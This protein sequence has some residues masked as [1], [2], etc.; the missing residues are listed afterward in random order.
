VQFPG[1]TQGYWSP[2]DAT[3]AVGPNHVVEVANSMIA[4]YTKNGVLQFS[5]PLDNSGSPGFFEGV[6]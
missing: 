1:V 2:P 5:A 6:G 4:F 3:L